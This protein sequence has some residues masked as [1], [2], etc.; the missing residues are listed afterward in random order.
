[1]PQPEFLAHCGNGQLV[2]AVG[3]RRQRGRERIARGDPTRIVVG[4][5]D[6]VHDRRGV[7]GGRRDVLDLQR[8][9]ACG[10]GERHGY[11]CVHCLACRRHG[12]DYRAVEQNAAG[13][14]SSTCST[15]ACL[16]PWI[17]GAIPVA[18]GEHDGAVMRRGHGRG[19]LR[20]VLHERLVEVLQLLA[21]RGNAAMVGK[22]RAGPGYSDVAAAR[23]IR[24]HRTVTVVHEIGERRDE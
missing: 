8:M 1:M 2:E 4:D 6:V 12:T 14:A 17:V 9:F 16:S 13:L 15:V 20:M 3:R 21:L 11:E 5:A 7:A 23:H 18:H 19:D 10:D 24:C 22:P